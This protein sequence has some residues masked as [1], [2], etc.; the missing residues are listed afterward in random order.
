MKEE[1]TK[2]NYSL[3]LESTFRQICRGCLLSSFNRVA[4]EV[5]SFFVFFFLYFELFCDVFIVFTQLPCIED[6]T[7]H[8]FCISKCAHNS[9]SSVK[10]NDISWWCYRTKWQQRSNRTTDRLKEMRKKDITIA[11]SN[12]YLCSSV[13]SSAAQISLILVTIKRFKIKHSNLMPTNRPKKKR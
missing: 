12:A 5:R 6:N 4:V 11:A 8:H 1:K 3:W 7:S 10:A 2:T 13:K 9:L